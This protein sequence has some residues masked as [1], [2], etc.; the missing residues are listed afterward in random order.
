M[1][2]DSNPAGKL[3]NNEGIPCLHQ[4]CSSCKIG[5]NSFI[6]I[7]VY[8]GSDRNI[9]VFRCVGCGEEITKQEKF[10]TSPKG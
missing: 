7:K 5:N 3:L 10:N 9:L 8:H 6:W 1:E 2:K 4:E